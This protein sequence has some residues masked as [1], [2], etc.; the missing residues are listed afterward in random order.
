MVVVRSPQEFAKVVEADNIKQDL[1]PLFHN[2]A[3][4]E[5][6]PIMHSHTCMTHV[7]VVEHYYELYTQCIYVL[8]M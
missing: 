1:I 2:L 3:S 8:Y 7:H 4:D 6:V 5:Q